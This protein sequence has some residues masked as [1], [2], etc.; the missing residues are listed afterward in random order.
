M[1]KTQCPQILRAVISAGRPL[2]DVVRLHFA[3]WY[4][5]SADHATMF[6]AAP[7]IPVAPH[8]VLSEQVLPAIY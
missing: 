2:D 7:H 1:Q 4:V 6:V 8:F 5:D 3:E